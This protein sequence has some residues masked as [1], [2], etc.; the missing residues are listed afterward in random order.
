MKIRIE[1][2]EDPRVHV[3]LD[4][5]QSPV[6]GDYLIWRNAGYVVSA[7]TWN[8]DGLSRGKD[9]EV[10]LSLE[11]VPEM[12]LLAPPAGSLTCMHCSYSFDSEYHRQR[13]PSF[14]R[15]ATYREASSPPSPAAPSSAATSPCGGER[16]RP[17]K[18]TP[19][20]LEGAEF[21]IVHHPGHVSVEI[22]AHLRDHVR[23]GLGT[24]LPII[25]LEEG[26]TLEVVR[27]PGG[28]D[29]ED[30]GAKRDVDVSVSLEVTQLQKIIDL[31]GVI[32]R[33]LGAR[34]LNG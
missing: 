4:M 8:L 33:R 12:P 30:L 18:T 13:C 32:A 10:T 19:V 15:P 6:E 34:F 1:T 26:M 22:A 23:V 21:I 25:V 31:L 28:R 24:D 9:L 27:R 20:S 14:S 16:R 29:G 17:M 11:R 2:D 3:L 5:E 7:V